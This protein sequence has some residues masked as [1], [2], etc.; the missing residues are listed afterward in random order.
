MF[1]HLLVPLDGSALAESVLPAAS[2]IALKEGARVTLLHLIE[3]KA[4]QSVHGQK[5]LRE[6]H[7]ADEYLKKIAATRFPPGVKV[8]THVHNEAISRLVESIVLHAGELAPDLIVMCS[9]GGQDL[10]KLLFGSVAQQVMAHCALPLLLVPPEQDAKFPGIRSI[11]VPLDGDAEHEHAL[12]AAVELAEAFG[13]E[14]ML[15][16]I[17]PT[18]STLSGQ[19][20]LIGSFLPGATKMTL[21]LAEQGAHEYLERLA[22]SINARKLTVKTLVKRG[23]PA[24][25]I[26]AVAREINAGL[27]VQG[28]HGKVGT[29]A[30]WSGSVTPKVIRHAGLAVLLVPRR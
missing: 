3:R 15:L 10:H 5:H 21:E 26:A 30:F 17:V 12:D 4:P 29:D 13:A 18:M 7:D 14:L 23:D 11:L 2:A 20:S 16:T 27:I 8:E 25:Q 24:A 19:Q 28:T 6:P 1:K 22:A 9:H